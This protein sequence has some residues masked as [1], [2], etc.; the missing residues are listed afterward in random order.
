MDFRNALKKTEGAILAFGGNPL[1]L[2]DLFVQACRLM[3]SF[4]AE[5]S[6]GGDGTPPF[7]DSFHMNY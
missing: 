3:D 7:N 5:G 4:D 1:I 6:F 2:I